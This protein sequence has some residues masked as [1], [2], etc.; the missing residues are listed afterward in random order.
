MSSNYWFR[1]L[2]YHFRHQVLNNSYYSPLLIITRRH[3]IQIVYHVISFSMTIDL[4]GICCMQQ[5]VIIES[6]VSPT[7]LIGATSLCMY[8]FDKGPFIIKYICS[9]QGREESDKSST[10]HTSG[11]ELQRT[12]GGGD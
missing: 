2:V 9:L 5:Y 10:L 1:P 11:V 3:F 12:I 7:Y 8:S 4:W 6:G